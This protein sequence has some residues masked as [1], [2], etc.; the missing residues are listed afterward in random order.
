MPC[1]FGGLVIGVPR[2]MQCQTDMAS[3][4]Y[5]ARGPDQVEV[6]VLHY[7]KVSPPDD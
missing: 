2:H 4:P 5:T 1:A 7:D 3:R 6:G